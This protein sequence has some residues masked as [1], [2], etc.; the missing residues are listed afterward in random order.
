M[1]FTLHGT[2]ERALNVLIF[3]SLRQVYKFQDF[4]NLGITMRTNPTL[5][6]TNSYPTLN[7]VNQSV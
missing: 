5:T 7:V 4:D 1:I 6:T 2:Y 3:C